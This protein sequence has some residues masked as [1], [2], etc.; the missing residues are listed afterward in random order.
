MAGLVLPKGTA[1]PVRGGYRVKGR[2]SYGSGIYHAEWVGGGASVPGQPRTAGG[3]F[4]LL[5]SNQVVIHDNWQ[6]AGLRASGSSD[7]SVEDQFVPEEMTIPLLDLF[8]GKVI[9]GGP[10]LRLGLSAWVA[11]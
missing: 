11:P 3:R 5:P 8:A 6:V 7:Y 2:W 10:A 4:V 1:E 9:T